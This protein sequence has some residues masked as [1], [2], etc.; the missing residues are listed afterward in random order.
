MAPIDNFA[1]I[2]LLALGVA[3]LVYLALEIWRVLG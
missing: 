2:T 1:G 3:S